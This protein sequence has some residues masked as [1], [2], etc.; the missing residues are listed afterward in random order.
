M[1]FLIK[2]LRVYSESE[3]IENGYVVINNG[4]I[5]SFG[6][7]DKLQDINI[8]H[9]NVVEVSKNDSIVPG[10]IDIH[11]HGSGGADIMDSTTA[12]LDTITSILPQEGTTSF[13]GTT[14][15]QKNEAIE[16]ALANAANYINTGNPPGTAEI[17]GIHLEGPFI[18]PLNAGAQPKEH[19]IHPNI[20]L[21]KKWMEIAH[22]KIKLVTLAPEAEN[23]LEFVQYLS[24]Q[25]IIASIGHSNATYHDVLTSQKAGLQHATHLFN[26]MRGLHH[27][28]PGVV[29]AVFMQTSLFAELI[30]DGI[31]VDPVIVNL[32]YNQIGKERIILITDSIRAKFLDDGTYDLG[33]QEVTVH[34]GKAILSD[35]TL[36]GSILKMNDALKNFMNYTGCALTDVIQMG[37]V[38]PAKQLGVFDRKGSITI[39]KDADLV[40]LD[41]NLQVKMT[42]CRGEIAFKREDVNLI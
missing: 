38:N 13:L 21:F 40:I 18:S 30:V 15:T 5:S 32:T 27:R 12:A 33:G 31:H 8:E 23:G 11:I 22:G 39:G 17:L 35:G 36:A 2:G 7:L 34:N 20:E 41:E 4:K 19:I 37:S 24:N 6:E 28:E 3:I 1:T 16:N 14:I 9:V 25:N 29:G 42:I 10:M 26:Q